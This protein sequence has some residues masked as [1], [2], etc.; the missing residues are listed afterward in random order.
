[1]RCPPTLEP[2]FD[3]DTLTLS[4]VCIAPTTSHHNVLF[5]SSICLCNSSLLLQVRYQLVA[6][7]LFWRQLRGST[8]RCGETKTLQHAHRSSPVCVAMS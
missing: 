8:W 1:L 5:T 7:H 6:T 2:F 4:S 3:F